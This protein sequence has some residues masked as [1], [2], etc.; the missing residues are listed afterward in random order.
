MTETLHWLPLSAQ[1][2]VQI[3]FLV[4]KAFLGLAP[5]YFCK[6]IMRPLSAISDRPICS[7]ECN[8]L[9]VKDVHLAAVCFC[10]SWSS[11]VELSP[12]KNR[13]SV[14]LVFLY[15]SPS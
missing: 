15:T 6:L 5:S 12:C 11:V 14:W 7:L 8:D 4:Y 3:T 1:I 10:F 9:L 13:C 2:H